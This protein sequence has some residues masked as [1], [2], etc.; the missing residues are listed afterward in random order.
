MVVLITVLIQNITWTVHTHTHTHTDTQH[1]HIASV[2]PVELCTVYEW[3]NLVPN[4][5]TYSDGHIH[6]YVHIP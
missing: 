3:V 2:R 1:I 4:H 6:M 5:P